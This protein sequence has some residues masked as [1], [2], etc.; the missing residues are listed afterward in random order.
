MREMRIREG[1]VPLA[2]WLAASTSCTS[3][4]EGIG[5]GD[6]DAAAGGAVTADGSGAP[7]PEAGPSLDASAEAD[8]GEGTC[9]TFLSMPFDSPWVSSVA[10]GGTLIVVSSG[11]RALEAAISGRDQR[12]VVTRSIQPSAGGELRV[13]AAVHV[14]PTPSATVGWTVDLV[15]LTCQIPMS[16]LT[17][18]LTPGGTLAAETVPASMASKDASF[19]LPP[20]GWADLVVVVKGVDVTVTF[21]GTT[22]TLTS[23]TSYASAVGCA[24]AAGTTANSNAPPTSLEIDAICVDPF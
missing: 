3:F 21:A 8:A 5:P 9:A 17:F 22:K 12:A 1:G 11:R 6:A 19:G 7:R 23:P 13:R 20:S 15:T 14:K 10:N 4:G 2:M 24:L 16:K 18:E